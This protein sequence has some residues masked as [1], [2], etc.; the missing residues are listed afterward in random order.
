M[1]MSAVLERVKRRTSLILS[2]AMLLIGAG[3]VFGV[4]WWHNRAPYAPE[5]LGATATLRVVDQSTAD[6]ALQ[7]ATVE[8]AEKSDQTLLGQVS[9]RRPPHQPDGGS[10]RIVVLDKRTRLMPG[11][12]AVTSSRPYDLSIGSDGSLDIAEKRYSWLQG[13]G[14]RE[15]NGSYWSVGNA[16]TVSSIDASPITF[17][18]VLHP[19]RPETPPE[20]MVASAPA[21]VTDLMVA[22]INVGPDGQVYW[23]QRLLN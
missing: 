2:V 20:Q 6:A 13:A 21:T 16:I 19:A 4:R 10:F 1:I 14:M 11:H 17:A 22:L 12:I 23:A 5:A 7:P 15:V 9:W 18:I 8:P 3:S